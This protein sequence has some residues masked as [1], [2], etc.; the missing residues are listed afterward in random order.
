MFRRARLSVKPNVKPGGRVPGPGGGVG[1]GTRGAGGGGVGPGTRG[2]GVGPGTREGEGG[3]GVEP[4]AGGGAPGPPRPENEDHRD[5]NAAASQEVG[6]SSLAGEVSTVLPAAESGDLQAREAAAAARGLDEKTASA[7]NGGRPSRPPSAAL[8][9][10]KRI[11]TLPNLAKPRATNSVPAITPA[12]KT[13]QGETPPSL[14]SNSIPLKNDASQ[15]E[16]TKLQSCPKSPTL[17]GASQAQH[18]S[19]PE[20]RTPVPQVP[21]FSPYKKSVLKQ[22]EVGPTKSVG[23]PQ[24]EE[25]CPLKERPSQDS[26]IQES[27]LCSTNPSLVK[28]VGNL[29]HE[30]LKRAR[31]LRELLRD[32]LRKERKVWKQM[33][34]I[35]DTSTQPERSK[36]IMRDFVYFIPFNNPMTSSIEEKKSCEKSPPAETQTAVPEPRTI[37]NEEDGDADEEENDSQLVVPRV[38]VAED[39]TIILDEESLTVEVTRIKAPVVESDDP[40]FERGSTTTYSSFR[41]SNYTKPWSNPETEMFF[42]AISMVGTDFSMIGQLFPHRQRIEIKNKFKREERANGWRIDKAFREKTAFDFQFFAKLLEGALTQQKNKRPAKSKKTQEKRTAKPR[43]K[44]RGKSTEEQRNS[45][46]DP[47]ADNLS[48]G[49]AVDARTAEKENEESP[50]VTDGQAAS[51]PVPGKKRRARKKKDSD[52][53]EPAAE[54]CSEGHIDLPKLSKKGRKSSRKCIVTAG[55]EENSPGDPETAGLSERAAVAEGDIAGNEKESANVAEGQTAPDSIQGK[56]RRTRKNKGDTKEPE[57]ESPSKGPADLPPLSRKKKS[58][59][60]DRTKSCEVLEDSVESVD[61]VCELPEGS[62]SPAAVTADGPSGEDEETLVLFDEDNESSMGLDQLSS[63]LES[64]TVSDVHD[65]P[66]SGASQVSLIDQSSKSEGDVQME[67]TSYKESNSET[68]GC[69]SDVV[70]AKVPAERACA[71]DHRLDSEAKDSAPSQPVRGR[72]SRPKPNLAKAS[73]K[74]KAAAQDQA[75]TE[76]E[77]CPTDHTKDAGETL[78]RKVDISVNL[79]CISVKSNA[80]Q[81]PPEEDSALQQGAEAG[82]MAEE[83]C[84]PQDECKLSAIKPAAL[85]RGRL[86]RPKPNVAR[87]SA[88]KGKP[89]ARG[90]TEEERND[91]ATEDVSKIPP[92]PTEESSISVNCEDQEREAS[93]VDERCRPEDSA[94]SPLAC[95]SPKYSHSEPTESALPSIGEHDSVSVDVGKGDTQESSVSLGS[96]SEPENN[97]VTVNTNPPVRGRLQRPKPSLGTIAGRKVAVIEKEEEKTKG[98]DGSGIKRTETA[99]S[100]VHQETNVAPKASSVSEENLTKGEVT[101]DD[102]ECSN[103]FHPVECLAVCPE[104]IEGRPDFQQSSTLKHIDFAEEVASSQE[105][106]KPAALK[107]AVF[108]RGRL[109]RPKPNVGRRA[110]SRREVFASQEATKRGDSREAE[111][112]T[113]VEQHT[114]DQLPSDPNAVKCD[115]ENASFPRNANKES[116]SSPGRAANLSDSS[117]QQALQSEGA[118]SSVNVAKE[119]ISTSPLDHVKDNT[120]QMSVMCNE[121]FSSSQEERKAVLLKPAVPTRGRFQ[122]PKPNV[123]R[124]AARTGL[125]ASQETTKGETNDAGKEQGIDHTLT[126]LTISSTSKNEEPV[127]SSQSMVKNVFSNSENAV[128]LSG[129][130]VEEETQLNKL[131][132][133]ASI[134]VLTECNHENTIKVPALTQEATIFEGQSTQTAVKPMRSRFQKPKPNIGRAAGKKETPVVVK[135]DAPKEEAGLPD[136]QPKLDAYPD[137]QEQLDRV[138]KGEVTDVL[139][140]PPLHSKDVLPISHAQNKHPSPAKDQEA[141]TKATEQNQSLNEGSRQSPTPQAP[142]LRGRLQR[143]KPNLVRAVARKGAPVTRTDK[144]PQDDSST[145]PVIEDKRSDADASDGMSTEECKPVCPTTSPKK[146]PAYSRVAEDGDV[147]KPLSVQNTHADVSASMNEN[148]N[149]SAAIK[150]AQLRRGRLVRPKPNLIKAV[151][152]GES[153]LKDKSDLQ[154]KTD[155]GDLEVS[156]TLHDYTSTPPPPSPTKRENAVNEVSVSSPIGKRKAADDSSK[157]VSPKRCRSSSIVQTPTCELDSVSLTTGGQEDSPAKRTRFGRQLKKSTPVTPPVKP[158]PSEHLSNNSEK[159]R[160]LRSTKPSACKSSESKPTSIK[161]RGKT[162]LVKL[163]ASQRHVEDDE[164]D[165]ELDFEEENYNL[166]P[167]KMNQAPVFVP[168]SLRSPKPVLAEVEESMEELDIPV[169]VL[170]VQNIIEDGPE[171]PKL[172]STPTT[173]DMSQNAL[174]SHAGQDDTDNSDGSKEAAMALISMGNS[175]FQSTIAIQGTCLSSD[176]GMKADMASSEENQSGQEQIMNHEPPVSP[177]FSINP[178]CTA[179]TSEDLQ[180]DKNT[181]ICEAVVEGNNTPLKKSRLSI[182]S[183]NCSVRLPRIRFAKPKPNLAKASGISRKRRSEPPAEAP[184]CSHSES[185]ERTT[186]DESVIQQ[187]EEVEPVQ[188]PDEQTQDLPSTKDLVSMKADTQ[189]DSSDPDLSAESTGPFDANCTIQYEQHNNHSLQEEAQDHCILSHNEDISGHLVVSDCSAEEATFILTLVEIPIHSDYPYSCDSLPSGESLPAPVLISSGPAQTIRQTQDQ[190]TESLV[191]AVPAS[192]EQLPSSVVEVDSM[193]TL[194]QVSRKRNASGTRGSDEAPVHKKPLLDDYLKQ[195]QEYEEVKDTAENNTDQTLIYTTLETASAALMPEEARGSSQESIHSV[196]FTVGE[197][198][199][200]DDGAATECRSFCETVTAE[201]EPVDP[202][203]KKETLSS[204]VHFRCASTAASSKASLE[205]PGRKPLGF[206]SLLCKDR[207]SKQEKDPKRSEKRLPKP[208]PKKASLAACKS[209]RPSPVP[210]QEDNTSLQVPSPSTSTSSAVNVTPECD[211]V[212]PEC[213]EMIM[214]A[215]EAS[216]TQPTEL[217]EEASSSNEVVSEEEA[218]TVSEYFFND[219][220]MPVDE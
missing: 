28:K 83:L 179:Y 203:V 214:P 75:L 183:L 91:A 1:P 97:S 148:S 213:D 13:S 42:L 87:V 187:Q 197:E 85:A 208:K 103:V 34:P 158:K 71:P 96:S 205:R 90:E 80:A 5:D 95:S 108:T 140:T 190:S 98:E 56:K 114:G 212:T 132:D 143:P 66:V 109:Q 115:E 45:L 138:D 35:M 48:E 218:P 206:V 163:R 207:N 17:N 159:E 76:V 70:S 54:T 134:S 172:S 57:G 184:E 63:M 189:A 130:H 116:S 60:K 43:K 22:P 47:E 24:K 33:H 195:Q 142:I 178:M 18:L 12:Q 169:E 38:K 165:A 139:G 46:S 44:K 65:S 37:P 2:G 81:N 191:T 220:F 59:R 64:T 124:A 167:D 141:D 86:H 19:L 126:T 92:T 192:F 185:N 32:E 200:H 219:I 25:L 68:S 210:I 8:Q 88:R 152:R 73:G 21:Q 176:H 11:S 119:E 153:Q 10:R 62:L 31:K 15:P 131:E 155:H 137:P 110:A 217:Q 199:L 147:S 171:D 29:E 202:T 127:S 175:A 173:A 36:M 144:K 194:N 146:S 53:K 4:A 201:G 30:R 149:L 177:S 84:A 82:A 3:G 204:A 123:G 164:D 113:G 160:T 79:D 100:N 52:T 181:E 14:P 170:D 211:D 156:P 50:C 40:I 150:P 55:E 105:N 72:L 51:D 120:A 122:R 161:S 89:E 162:T 102:Q 106:T 186:L 145:V 135:K 198:K 112:D 94:S 49:E 99:F 39:G 136:D 117:I 20:K 128:C 180:S 121:E 125:S 118:L 111:K 74:K 23:S 157:E 168:Y 67:T 7:S 215:S 129:K 151:N 209:Q 69:K 6:G 196:A 104:N 166:S 78:G 133:D 61:N 93:P 27:S 9:R 107:P 182:P 16:K 101:M 154:T 77:T 26:S 174:T 41:R 193:R 188:E 58:R 216:E